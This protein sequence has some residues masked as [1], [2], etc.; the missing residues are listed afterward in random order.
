MGIQIDGGITIGSGI[1][2]SPPPS[3]MRAL[4]SP[5]G[6]S[7]FDAASADSWF[8]VSST[9]YANV[10]AGMAGVTTVGY[11][12]VQITTGGQAFSQ[13]FGATLDI[14]NATVSTGN[15]VLGMASRT[16]TGG[17]GTLT[18]RPYISTTFRGTYTTVGTGNLV[19]T[20]AATPFYW[21]RKNPADAVAST[22]Y[23]AVGVPSAGSGLGWNSIVG[24]WGPNG[25]T[26]GAYSSNMSSWTTYNNNVPAQQWMLTNVQQW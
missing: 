3:V 24:P 9:D 6:Q 12:D 20:T 26:G 11:T 13:N 17:T 2:I 23:V 7:A 5:A 22:S 21:L 18:F 1:T 25:A 15:Y 8:A 16:A 4:L 14:G 19:M 10:K